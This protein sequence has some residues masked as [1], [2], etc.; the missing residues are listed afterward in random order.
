MPAPG[1]L[2]RMAERGD[3]PGSFKDSVGHWW[4][5]VQSLPVSDVRSQIDKMIGDDKTIRDMIA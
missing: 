1:T 5:E 2:R 3:V 4:V